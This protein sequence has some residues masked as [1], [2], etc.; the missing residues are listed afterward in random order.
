VESPPHAARDSARTSPAHA[1][2]SRGVRMLDMMAGMVE[3]GGCVAD[4][5]LPAGPGVLRTIS[6]LPAARGGGAGRAPV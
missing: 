6:V 3:V 1:R 2:G 5:G 4:R